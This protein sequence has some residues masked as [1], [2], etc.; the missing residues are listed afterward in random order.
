VPF[1]DKMND[2]SNVGV[3]AETTTILTMSMMIATSKIYCPPMLESKTC[4]IYRALQGQLHWLQ[5]SH[6]HSKF[7]QEKQRNLKTFA[8][9]KA[10]VQ[11]KLVLEAH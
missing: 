9:I 11:Q 2:E 8:D 3:Y 1:P 5:D 10:V 4:C 7:R 6:S